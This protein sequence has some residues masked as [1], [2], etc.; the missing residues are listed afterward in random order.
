MDESTICWGSGVRGLLWCVGM[1]RRVYCLEYWVKPD[2]V[3][4][5]KV[6]FPRYVRHCRVSLRELNVVSDSEANMPVQRRRTLPE[7]R[8]SPPGSYYVPYHN[9]LVKGRVSQVC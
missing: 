3:T 6:S 4:Y 8:R 5:C 7:R 9:D 1:A 2:R